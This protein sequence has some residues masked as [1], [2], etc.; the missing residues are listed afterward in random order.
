MTLGR[1]PEEITLSQVIEA[2]DGS[3]LLNR[4]LLRSGKCEL[5]P[6]CAAHDVWADIQARFIHYLD[7]VTM[8]ELARRQAKKRARA[9]N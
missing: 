1:P 5:E 8:K 9:R 7:A 4:C 3:I 2:M 6:Y